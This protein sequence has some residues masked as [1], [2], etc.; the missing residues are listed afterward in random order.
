M[1][2]VQ[3]R[4][5]ATQKVTAGGRAT[6]SVDSQTKKR[7]SIPEHLGR[8]EKTKGEAGWGLSHGGQPYRADRGSEVS[9][10]ASSVSISLGLPAPQAPSHSHS[11]SNPR[12][13][14]APCHACIDPT[15]LPRPTVPLLSPS[16]IA[17]DLRT[18]LSPEMTDSTSVSLFPPLSRMRRSN[19]TSVLSCATG[20][21]DIPLPMTWVSEIFR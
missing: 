19:R 7:T 15:C 2:E 11:D 12:P 8:R 18:Q 5:R 3:G 20:L 17:I 1:K 4:D 6:L 13:L 9:D 14:E 16:P 21:A 10:R